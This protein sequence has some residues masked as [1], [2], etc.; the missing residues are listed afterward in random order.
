MKA[1]PKPT[2]DLLSTLWAEPACALGDFSRALSVDHHAIRI[3]AM[4]KP[5]RM[6]YLVNGDSPDSG[7]RPERRC[8][9]GLISYVGKSHDAEI[10]NSVRG[11]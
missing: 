2:L 1:S 10:L 11:R 6:T 8:D 3:W 9:G 4:G 7:M 5:E